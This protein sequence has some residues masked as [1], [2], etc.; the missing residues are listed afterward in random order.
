MTH[1]VRA[2][3]TVVATIALV[4]PAWAV[5]GVIEINQAAVFAGNI[6]PGDMPGFPAVLTRPGSYRLTG[7]LDVTKQQDGSPQSNPQNVTAI[8]VEAQ[9]VTVDLNGFEI[10]GPVS[11]FPCNPTGGSGKG[12]DA[13]SSARRTA[14]L[15]G[16]IRGMG[17]D[18]VDLASGTVEQVRAFVNAGRGIGVEK[19]AVRNCFAQSNGGDGIEAQGVIAGNHVESSGDDGIVSSFGAL[20]GNTA[21][22]NDGDGISATNSTVVQNASSGNGDFGLNGDANTGYSNNV[23]NGNNSNAAQVSAGPNEIPPGSNVC[24]GNTVCP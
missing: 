11:C 6:T 2:F 3:T 15:N 22:T 19:G 4:A 1:I 20:T 5:D 18:G 16:S 14:V 7:N 12:V 21:L 17:S 13:S 23:F 24:G 8:L 9:D 10:M